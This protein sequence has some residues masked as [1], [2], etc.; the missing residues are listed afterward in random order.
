MRETYFFGPFR[1]EIPEE[2]LWHNE[3]LVALTPTPCRVLAALVRGRGR[4]VSNQEL[5]ASVWPGG[6][7]KE[8]VRFAIWQVREAL[9]KYPSAQNYIKTVFRPGSPFPHAGNDESSHHT[10]TGRISQPCSS[11]QRPWK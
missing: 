2:C 1:L 3:Q 8:A 6:A 5:I 4:V 10:R 7:N 11:D 9:G